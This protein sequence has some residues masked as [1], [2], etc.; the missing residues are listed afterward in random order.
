MFYF[1][2]NYFF[3]GIREE[4]LISYWRVRDFSTSVLWPSPQSM[5]LQLDS[6]K[7]TEMMLNDCL[8]VIHCS[9]VKFSQW[10]KAFLKEIKRKIESNKRLTDFQLHALEKIWDKI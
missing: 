1:L 9:N 5:L 6:D 4:E 10:D 3:Y 8:N 2:Q 7:Q